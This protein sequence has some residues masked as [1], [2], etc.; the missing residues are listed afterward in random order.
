MDW[1]CL[2]QARC[3]LSQSVVAPGPPPTR[4]SPPRTPRSPPHTRDRRWSRSPPTHSL[5]ACNGDATLSIYA[6]ATLKTRIHM[7]SY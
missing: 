3:Q 2:G 6:T 7:L 4:G 1:A 5:H